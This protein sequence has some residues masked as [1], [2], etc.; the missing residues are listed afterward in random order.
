MYND[1]IM[2]ETFLVLS[3]VALTYYL[4]KE[5]IWKGPNT[6]SNILKTRIEQSIMD[7]TYN[8]CM[9]KYKNKKYEN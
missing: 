5:K 8:N 3:G 7:R 9:E 1:V 4:L 2:K 6:C